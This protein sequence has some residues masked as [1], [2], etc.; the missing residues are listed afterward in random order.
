ME[1]L[2]PLESVVSVESMLKV[3]SVGGATG[4]FGNVSADMVTHAAAIAA[5][6]A[7]LVSAWR[8]NVLFKVFFIMCFAAQVNWFFCGDSAEISGGAYVNK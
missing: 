6:R 2:E 4:G 8:E 3:I 7:K 5:M 1:S